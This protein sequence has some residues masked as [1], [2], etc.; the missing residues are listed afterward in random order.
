MSTKKI[1]VL[2]LDDEVENLNSF[3]ANFRRLFNVSLANSIDEAYSIIESKEIH[4]VVSDHKM[5]HITGIEFFETLC[6]THPTIVRV[7]LTGCSDLNVV[8][9]SV[10]RGQIFKYLYKPMDVELVRKTMEMA[11]KKFEEDKKNQMEVV[12]LIETN[13]KL[14][15]MLRQKLID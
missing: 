4:V 3:N 13:E 2:Y 15:F 8:V 10:N 9:D 1:S 7:L 5:P 11:F 12:Q 6:K 14:E